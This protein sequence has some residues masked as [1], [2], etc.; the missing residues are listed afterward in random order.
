M[1]VVLMNDPSGIEGS[2]IV[3]NRIIR[4]VI[5][6]E[7]KIMRMRSAKTTSNDPTRPMEHIILIEVIAG[8]LN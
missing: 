3:D 8:V 5:V 2:M 1:A 4:V 6:G 7:E